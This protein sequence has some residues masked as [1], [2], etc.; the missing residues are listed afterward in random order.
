[1]ESILK[2]SSI[3]IYDDK[4]IP[5]SIIP[6]YGSM[7]VDKI[8]QVLTVLSDCMPSSFSFRLE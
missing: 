2:F 3:V 5:Y 1:M 6:V 4:D 8:N 7:T